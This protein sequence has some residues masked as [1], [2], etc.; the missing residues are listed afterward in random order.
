MGAQYLHIPFLRLKKWV[1]NCAPCTL[2]S[3][4]PAKAI[5]NKHTKVKY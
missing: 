5:E 2:G 3:Y 4:A 1:R